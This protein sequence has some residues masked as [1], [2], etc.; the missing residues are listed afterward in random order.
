MKKLINIL[1]II[2]LCITSCKTIQY[3][4]IKGDTQIEYRDTT[5][6]RDSLIY[7][8]VEVVKEVVPYMEPLYMETSLA[9][10]EAH[11]DTTTN[12]LKGSIRNKK[13]ITE[14]IK[15]KEKIVYRDSIVTQE[16]PVEVEVEKEVKV[17]PWYERILWFLSIIGCTSLI[18]IG[19]KI[20]V[21][22][23]KI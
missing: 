13:G 11:I 18:Y 22:A 6:Y 12:T 8:P 7:T 17:H 16:I 15:Y 23:F 10:A 4:P 20:Y 1:I 21:K 19:Y 5:I 9:K 2:L 14:H 3:V